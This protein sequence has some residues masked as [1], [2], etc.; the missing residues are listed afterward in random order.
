MLRY[1]SKC[2]FILKININDVGKVSF[3]C[4]PTQKTSLDQNSSWVNGWVI[5]WVTKSEAHLSDSDFN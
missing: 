2:V 5:E 3:A 4:K 1:P